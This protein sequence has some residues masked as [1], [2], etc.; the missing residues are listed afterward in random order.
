MGLLVD[1]DG[2]LAGAEADA[3]H[4]LLAASGGLTEWC[5]HVRSFLVSFSRPG[6]PGQLE[7]L[8]ALGCVGVVGTGVDVELA[9]IWRPRVFLGSMPRT[10]RRISSSGDFS[11]SSA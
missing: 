10:E 8:G 11:S 4:R 2:A 1:R 5:G 7:R 6:G 9:S 3:G